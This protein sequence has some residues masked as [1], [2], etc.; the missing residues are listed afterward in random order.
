[1]AD[2]WKYAISGFNRGVPLGVRAAEKEEER[3]RL[4]EAEETRKR[5]LNERYYRQDIK[6]AE[7]RATAAGIR[8]EDVA[9]RKQVQA[10]KAASDAATAEH[11]KTM[12]RMA[13]TTLGIKQAQEK[14]SQKEFNAKQA[15]KKART[16]LNVARA[17]IANDN[18]FEAAATLTKYYND[19]VQN[20]DEIRIF[21]RKFHA[22]NPAFEGVSKNKNVVIQSRTTGIAAFKNL[23]AVIERAAAMA[24]V[25]SITDAYRGSRKALAAKNAA[26]AESPEL[27]DGKYYIKTYKMGPGGVPVFDQQIPYVGKV[28]TAPVREALKAELGT[29]PTAEEVKTKLGIREKEKQPLQ[30]T[31]KQKAEL[32]GKQLDAQKKR[33]DLALRPF[34]QSAKS[35]WDTKNDTFTVGGSNAIT[36]AQKIIDKSK[37]GNLTSIERKNLPKAIRALDLYDQIFGSVTASVPQ[38]AGI[39]EM[40]NIVPDAMMLGHKPKRPPL[41]SYVQ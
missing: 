9:H 24:N 23:N 33:L 32:A 20:G 39:G 12:Q 38:R 19:E 26:A 2:P 3:K 13:K 4:E 18:D 22:D 28:E 6:T 14:R 15:V 16:T 25:K 10:D 8:K 29:E 5:E 34:K 21:Q 31:A 40:K 36:E 17:Q 7:D 27:I 11:R 37:T 41:E 35:V 1:M 30:T